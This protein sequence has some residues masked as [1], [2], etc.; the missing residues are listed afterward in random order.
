[1]QIIFLINRLV[2]KMSKKGNDDDSCMFCPTNSPKRKLEPII[3]LQLYLKDFTVK[4]ISCQPS[5][6][7]INQLF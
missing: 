5:N 3:F 1:M 6:W 4:Y 2:N 7:I